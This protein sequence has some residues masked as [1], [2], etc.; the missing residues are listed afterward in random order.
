MLTLNVLVVGSWPT[1]VNFLF[2]ILAYFD[3]LR[4]LWKSNAI[5]LEIVLSHKCTMS[6]YA[7]GNVEGAVTLFA[8]WLVWTDLNFQTFSFVYTNENIIYVFGKW[9]NS[10]WLR[11]FTSF[12]IVRS[13]SDENRF[14]KKIGTFLFIFVENRKFIRKFQKS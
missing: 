12:V 1:S 6:M 8:E 10:Y 9:L 14:S 5:W 7:C 2:P 3:S 4:I 11:I 13:C